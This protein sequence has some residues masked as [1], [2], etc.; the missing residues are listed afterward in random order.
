MHAQAKDL[1][2][3]L[4]S[5]TILV[6][7]ILHK[8]RAVWY[9]I[10]LNLPGVQRSD[11]DA[12]RA[13]S[14]DSSNQGSNCEACSKKLTD[15][16]LKQVDPPPSKEAL[17]RAIKKA[18][19]KQRSRSAQLLFTSAI[20]GL[21]GISL[22]IYYSLITTPLLFESLPTNIVM[23]G[24][25]EDLKNLTNLWMDEKVQ[26]INVYGPPGWGKSTL[27]MRF[28]HK[29]VEG[30]TSVV[31]VN[32]NDTDKFSMLQRDI[33]DKIPQCSSTQDLPNCI[34]KQFDTAGLLIILD[35]TDFAWFEKETNAKLES[36]ME[37]LQKYSITIKVII[38]S[39]R[40]LNWKPLDGFTT[41][42]PLK[43]SNETCHEIFLH[44]HEDSRLA[45]KVCQRL[46]NMPLPVKLVASRF[47]DSTDLC[48][49][50]ECI[51]EWEKFE[52]AVQF[53]YKHLNRS[54][55]V[56]ASLLVRFPGSFT[57]IAVRRILPDRMGDTQATKCLTSLLKYSF[58]DRRQ[59]KQSG[60]ILLVDL[61]DRL[62]F[63][64]LI[65][66]TIFKFLD[67]DSYYSSNGYNILLVKFGSNFFT[68]YEP[69]MIKFWESMDTVW[70]MSY[71]KIQSQEPELTHELELQ[72]RAAAEEQVLSGRLVGM[73]CFAE[74]VNINSLFV[75]LS[76]NRSTT[77]QIAMNY[78]EYRWYSP[79]TL[80]TIF[81]FMS[82]V[83]I[84]DHSILTVLE[85]ACHHPN[86]GLSNPVE[87][88]T[89][90]AN[91]FNSALGTDLPTPICPDCDKS[92]V[93]IQRISRCVEKIE[94]LAHIGGANTTNGTAIF[95]GTLYHLCIC[96]ARSCRVL[97][98]TDRDC[99]RVWEYWLKANV[100]PLYVNFCNFCTQSLIEGLMDKDSNF[101]PRLC[102]SCDSS[103]S[104]GIRSYLARKH[105]QTIE[106]I[107]L[108]IEEERDTSC[109]DL[110][111]V[112]GAMILCSI[113][114]CSD[115]AESK[116]QYLHDILPDRVHSLPQLYSHF[117]P[118]FEELNVTNIQL[119]IHNN[120]KIPAASVIACLREI[121]NVFGEHYATPQ[122]TFGWVF[123]NCT[124]EYDYFHQLWNN[125]ST[126][127]SFMDYFNGRLVHRSI[128]I[129]VSTFCLLQYDW[130][131]LLCSLM[132]VA[133]L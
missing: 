82:G 129:Q 57:L 6:L 86:F 23:F 14:E 130:D 80:L 3:F 123:P 45:Q 132:K 89:A 25:E 1:N 83:F 105:V 100:A 53:S 93:L 120:T 90:L 18:Y 32:M 22:G 133:Y 74:Y 62:Q 107:K 103:L 30:G 10:G 17:D 77:L 126:L 118:F 34:G 20:V 5:L 66:E 59:Y 33:R 104:L 122:S 44:K 71:G 51:A 128:P 27:V 31:Y 67:G 112:I 72:H 39:R 58:L 91:M 116:V 9:K 131:S 46:G 106:F 38:T 84:G 102:R 26:F 40:D 13:D 92:Q 121:I 52:D 43:V 7:R 63:H 99:V 55:Q 73:T 85:G 61:K 47:A 119:I 4:Y 24:R 109:S 42:T 29:V 125:F 124:A 54:V 78:S 97:S 37:S 88:I 12:I 49:E 56:C 95:Y 108:A 113:G 60:D 48:E 16:W 98:T 87:T 69:C 28:G 19:S 15:L 111:G 41:Y 94:Q 2:D 8:H 115:S 114:Y 79:Q 64:M 96:R 101:V 35:N 50:D 36:F 127:T 81:P 68:Y 75:F 117:E 11:L 70:N 76:A 110:K 65:K 21:V